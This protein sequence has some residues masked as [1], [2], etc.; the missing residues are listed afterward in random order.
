MN[1]S[2]EELKK[3]TEESLSTW[4]SFPSNIMVIKT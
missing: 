1:E 3:Q 4:P 2:I